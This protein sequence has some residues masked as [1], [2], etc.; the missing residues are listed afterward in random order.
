VQATNG[1][2]YGTASQGGAYYNNGTLFSLSVGLGPFVE[3][4]PAS[5]AVGATVI[6]LGNNL[7]GSTA[8]SFN[9]TAS[10]FT[11]ASSTEITTT[12]PAGA[13]T[14]TLKV[15]TPSGTLNSNVA[16]RVT[17]QI[18]SF[19]PTSGA[20][21]TAVTITGVSLTQTTRVTFGDVE[22]TAFTVNSDTQVT[23]TV[24]TDAVTGKIKV[25]TPGG[26]ASNATVFTVTP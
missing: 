12:V 3:T 21:G 16:F 18:S 15:T 8:V 25:T 2:F 23:A 1:N 13:T 14:G 22:A 11:V 17:P 5:G 10:A 20:A 24:P 19:T 9:G 26:T 4:L 6:I 7:T